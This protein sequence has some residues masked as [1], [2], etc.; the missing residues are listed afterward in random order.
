MRIGGSKESL[1]PLTAPSKRK[2]WKPV[3]SVSLKTEEGNHFIVEVSPKISG[4]YEDDFEAIL[5]TKHPPI[6]VSSSGSDSEVRH[7]FN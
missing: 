7:I 6:H 5:V 3:P 4:M 2:G 1:V